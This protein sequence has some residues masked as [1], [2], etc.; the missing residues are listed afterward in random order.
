MLCWCAD[1]KEM[2]KE[3]IEAEM[4]SNHSAVLILVPPNAIHS[5]LPWFFLRHSFG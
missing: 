2:S 3:F 5:V 1:A 4:V